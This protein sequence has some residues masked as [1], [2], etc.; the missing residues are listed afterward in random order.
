M[1]EGPSERVL[2]ARFNP[3]LRVYQYVSSLLMLLVSIIGIPLIPIWLVVGWVWSGRYFRS[4]RCELDDRRLRVRRGVLFRKTRTIPLDRIQDFTLLD[5]PIQRAFG[6]CT[7]RIETAG[8]SSPQGSADA[9]L[10]GLMDAEEF[11]EVVLE[12]RDRLVQ[13]MA[14]AAD[15][16][17][18]ADAAGTPDATQGAPRALPA[19]EQVLVEI[20]DLLRRMEEHL[21]VA[22]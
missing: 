15:A 1:A 7:L 21:R 9:N 5:G 18:T 2:I 19:A 11:Q 22:R 20:R 17:R 10:T 16:S 14:G 6:L 13:Q 12:R 4:L 3:K 8:Q